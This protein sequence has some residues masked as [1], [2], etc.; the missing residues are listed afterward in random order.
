VPISS[1]TERDAAARSGTERAR[2]EM[3]RHGERC[4]GTERDAVARTEMQW[5]GQR[6]SGTERDAVARREMQWHGERCMAMIS[7][8]R[9]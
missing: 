7:G 4:S 5:H 6:C 3:Q 9:V 8:F 2:R 1:G